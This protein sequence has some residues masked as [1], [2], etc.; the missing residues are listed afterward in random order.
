MEI[1]QQLWQR[2]EVVLLPWVEVWSS[3]LPLGQEALTRV[4]PE[5]MVEV[6]TGPWR[7]LVRIFP[8]ASSFWCALMQR[9][10]F[11][12][13]T[14]CRDGQELVSLLLFGCC[15]WLGQ[16]RDPCRQRYLGTHR[17]GRE[18]RSLLAMDLIFAL[19]VAVGETTELVG[20]VHQIPGKSLLVL[21][22]RVAVDTN[23]IVS[24]VDHDDSSFGD[25][26]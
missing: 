19:S 20:Y 25:S 2:N 14:K 4:S 13:A 11:G 22:S 23:I 1:T 3:T 7:L 12:N 8:G 5:L 21:P 9:K 10:E 24:S 16:G 6:W 18:G 26:H 17:V 15:C